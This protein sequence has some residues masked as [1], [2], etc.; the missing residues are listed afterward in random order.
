MSIF[1]Q[2]R[3][4]RFRAFLSENNTFAPH[5]HRQTELILAL[6]G[7]VRVTVDRQEYALT[8]Q[9]GVI[10]FPNRLHSLHTDTHSRILLCIFDTGFCPGYRSVFE[11]KQATY[12][13]FRLEEAGSHGQVAAEGLRQL[14]AQ[15]SRREPVSPYCLALSQ[16]Y[17]TLLLACLFEKMPLQARDAGNGMEPEQKLLMYL[18]AH[19][20]DPLSLETLSRQ[21][22]VSRFSLS[23]L[24]ADRLHTTF[25]DYVNTKRLEAAMELLSSTRL[26]VTQIALESGFGSSRTFFRE[27][28]RFTGT[29]PAAYRRERAPHGGPPTA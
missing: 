29:T 25:P 24:F 19:F 1:Y 21:F 22:G 17:L 14:S 12:P 26:S 9:S 5:L 11:H 2:K 23:R 15:T 4:E 18:D 28:R 6:D 3:T 7:A 8:P 27:F 20:A 13:V 16:G 10:V